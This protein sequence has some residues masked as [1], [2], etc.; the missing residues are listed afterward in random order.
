[1]RRRTTEYAARR[2]VAGVHQKLQE[3]E[4]G[5]GGEVDSE[6]DSEVQRRLS[7][8]LWSQRPVPG[9]SG[10]DGKSAEFPGP[11]KKWDS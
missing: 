9:S 5:E 10:S 4:G 3:L 8:L 11:T 7:C 1:M 2:E 6:V